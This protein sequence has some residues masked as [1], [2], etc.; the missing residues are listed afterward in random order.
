MTLADTE[1]NPEH[2]AVTVPK[3]DPMEPAAA[4]PLVAANMTL[5]QLVRTLTSAAGSEKK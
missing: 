1:V 4:D 5:R 2:R 3:A